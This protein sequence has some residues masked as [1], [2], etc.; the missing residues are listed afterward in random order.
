[1]T[2]PIV[3]PIKFVLYRQT[4]IYVTTSIIAVMF[5]NLGWCQQG[6]KCVP[7]NHKGPECEGDW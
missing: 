5:L 3:P 4:V 2:I 1:M 7:G 6:N